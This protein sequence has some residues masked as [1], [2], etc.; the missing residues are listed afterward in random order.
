MMEGNDIEYVRANFSCGGEEADEL[1]FER[2]DVFELIARNHKRRTEWWHVR[3]AEG[4]AGCVPS[5]YVTECSVDGSDLD[6]VG[7]SGGSSS[8]GSGDG[9]AGA[10]ARSVDIAAVTAAAGADLSFEVAALKATAAT[11]NAFRGLFGRIGRSLGMDV[12]IDDP[13]FDTL[14]ENVRNVEQLL[15]TLRRAAEEFQASLDL[16]A[17]EKWSS[18]TQTMITFFVADEALAK[19]CCKY[20]EASTSMFVSSP[21]PTSVRR[22]TDE[23]LQQR[24]YAP[25]E[26]QLEFHTRLRN[27]VRR[28]C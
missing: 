4:T 7:S 19:A 5:N 21:D 13:M 9:A 24:V 23:E 10:A 22:R 12:K 28:P 17:N 15:T 2:G 1:T 6:A 20:K 27:Q 8:G 11:K 16:L 25:I 3:N 26:K 18:L 14:F